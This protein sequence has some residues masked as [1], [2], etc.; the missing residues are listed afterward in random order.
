[1]S[2]TLETVEEIDLPHKLICASV[3][4]A[5]SNKVN[6]YFSPAW[7]GWDASPSHGN[8]FRTS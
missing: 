1:M 5:W 6:Q 3:S 2:Q 7:M 4:V 8:L